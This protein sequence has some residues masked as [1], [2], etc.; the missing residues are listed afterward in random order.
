MRF[1]A[2]HV[3]ATTAG[4]LHRNRERLEK[5]KV[6][7]AE[8]LRSLEK[9]AAGFREEFGVKRILLIGSVNT[10]WFSERSDVDIVVEGLDPSRTHTAERRLLEIVSAPVDLLL[11]EE[12]DES[13]RDAIEE[14]GHP[15]S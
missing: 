10:N 7:R 13:F 8:I 4:L 15:I 6:R 2:K 5:R 3:E 9:A 11:M 12:L 1:T 14:E